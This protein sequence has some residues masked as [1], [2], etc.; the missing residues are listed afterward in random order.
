MATQAVA[1]EFQL[2]FLDAVFRLAPEHLNVVMEKLGVVAQISDHKAL[3][4][5][6]LADRDAAPS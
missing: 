6:K 2:Q 1:L 5:A 4:G 3:I